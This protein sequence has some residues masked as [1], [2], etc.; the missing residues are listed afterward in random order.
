[1][2]EMSFAFCCR[3]RLVNQYMTSSKSL[4]DQKRNSIIKGEVHSFTISLGYAQYPQQAKNYDGL[5]H[6][7]DAALYEVKLRGKQGCAAY[8]DCFRRIRKQLGFGFMDVS[9]NLPGAFLIY[10]A[11]PD[12]DE[13][14]FA[15]HEMLHLC[16]CKDMDEFFAYTKQK[17]CNLINKQK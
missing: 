8:K 2:V 4:Q 13:L 12:D 1:M 6:C 3:I 5:I 11:D 16:G 14:L 10:K 15:N 7:A 17:F 9:K